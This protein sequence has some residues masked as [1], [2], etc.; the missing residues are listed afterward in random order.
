[1]EQAEL[2]VRTCEC[3][4]LVSCQGYSRSEPASTFIKPGSEM[5]K[6]RPSC[7]QSSR[8]FYVATVFCQE[9]LSSSWPDRPLGQCTP[10]TGEREMGKGEIPL[11]TFLS[12]RCWASVFFNNVFRKPLTPLDTLN[13]KEFCHF[14]SQI[15]CYP[16]LFF[17]LLSDNRFLQT[18]TYCL[19]W[20]KLV[21]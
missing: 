2:T 15:N 13:E 1:M 5:E 6:P 21:L 11:F 14:N 17:L 20:V 18:I 19:P 3:V 9:I 12:I 16:W 8:I 10:N 4:S 7:C